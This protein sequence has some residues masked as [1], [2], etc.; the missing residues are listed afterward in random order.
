M[1]S[2]LVQSAVSEVRVPLLRTAGAS[3]LWLKRNTGQVHVRWR[4]S[5]PLSAQAAKITG[6][7]CVEL[8]EKRSSDKAGSRSRQTCQETAAS[9]TAVRSFAGSMRV[10]CAN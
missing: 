2:A 6:K 1:P 8:A 3:Q 4:D 9:Y 7:S 10:L 5:K